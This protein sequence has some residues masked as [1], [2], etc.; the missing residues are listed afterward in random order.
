M[1]A[2]AAATPAAC[3]DWMA[4]P[5]D[6]TSSCTGWR[7]GCHDDGDSDG[8]GDGDSDN[9]GYGYGDSGGDGDNDGDGG[10]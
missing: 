8:D 2:V 5:T 4:L 10:G 1:A 9:D 6:S 3:V 7:Q